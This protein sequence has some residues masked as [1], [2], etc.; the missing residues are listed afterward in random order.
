MTTPD[1]Q[2][3]IQLSL[4][5]HLDSFNRLVE[6]HQDAVFSVALRMVRN[7]ATA[8]DLTQDAFISA[9]KNLRSYR[10][11]VFKAWLMRIVRNAT[12]DHLRRTKRRPETSI[13]KDIVMFSNTIES[14][15]RSPQEWAQSGELREI[16]THCLGALSEDQRMAVVLVDIEGYQYDEAADYMGVSIG[17]IKSRLNRAR[18][19]LRDCLQ[20]HPE[21][22]PD[23]M[24][25]GNTQDQ[26]V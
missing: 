5:G 12:Y 19:R 20:T 15:D 22:L 25:L 2:K 23:S 16:I 7:H 24:R 4:E 3:L 18:A 21:H 26:E 13:D 10:G 11:G 6:M 9:F 1:E 14:D 8:E 17:T